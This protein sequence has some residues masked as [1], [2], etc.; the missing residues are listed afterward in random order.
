MN[1]SNGSDWDIGFNVAWDAA[2][3]YSK[4]DASKAWDM[5][6][7]YAIEYAEVEIYNEGWDDATESK[8]KEIAILNNI[9]EKYEEMIEI[10]KMREDILKEIISK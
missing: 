4:D 5:G 3:E 8:N 6:F 7:D 1:K 10:H 9:I 2:L